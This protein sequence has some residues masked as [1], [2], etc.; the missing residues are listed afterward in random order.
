MTSRATSRPTPSDADATPS[1]TRCD[2][3]W[4]YSRMRALCYRDQMGVLGVWRMVWRGRQIAP[5][6]SEPSQP[7][8]QR[9]L[10]AARAAARRPMPFERGARRATPFEAQRGVSGR[11]S[12][13]MRLE[14]PA[15]VG[16]S[17]QPVGWY[18]GRRR[19]GRQAHLCNAS[20][21]E[22]ACACTRHTVVEA[23]GARGPRLGAR[24]CGGGSEGLCSMLV[25]LSVTL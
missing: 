8:D 18:S 6:P 11:S 19:R 17:R 16:C 12:G 24:A 3:R 7:G 10:S 21:C 2:L 15:L 25:C 4:A 22:H 5:T 20:T 1:D 14:R 9:H 13:H 23:A